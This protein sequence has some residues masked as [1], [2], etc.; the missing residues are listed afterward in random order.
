MMMLLTA[1]V[2]PHL[3]NGPFWASRM[4]PEADKCK[5]YWWANLLA[6]S[7]F[8]EVD[9]QVKRK[10]FLNFLIVLKRYVYVLQYLIYI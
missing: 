9:N 4:W 7:N 6:A 2:I 3:G 5:N 1:F 10:A 8:I